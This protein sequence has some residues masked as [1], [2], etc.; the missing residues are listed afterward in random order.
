MEQYF[1]YCVIAF[2][3]SYLTFVVSVLC[4]WSARDKLAS[5]VALQRP[6]KI[7]VFV[8]GLTSTVAISVMNISFFGGLI[9]GVLWILKEQ[10]VL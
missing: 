7:W 5:D 9:L 4:L 6:T 3:I 1:W 10:G 8:T 2:V